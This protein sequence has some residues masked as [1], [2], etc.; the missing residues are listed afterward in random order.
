[1]QSVVDEERASGGILVIAKFVNCRNSR[2][3]EFQRPLWRL[4]RRIVNRV[5]R[6]Y[7]AL[8]DPTRRRVLALLRDRDMTAGELAS[9]FELS[10]PTM[11][12]HFAVLREADLIQADKVGTTINYRLNVSVLEEALMAL[13]DGLGVKPKGAE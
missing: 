5:N 11:S 10:W 2:R 4:P 6:V 13:M 1:M 3:C 9:Q 7:R 12:G 8:A